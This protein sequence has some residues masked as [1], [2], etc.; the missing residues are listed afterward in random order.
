M[1]DYQAVKE[2]GKHDP[3]KKNK[4]SIKSDP[5]LTQTVKLEDYDIKSYCKCI[6]YVQKV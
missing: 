3:Y 5:E 1:K 6:L 2:V 4:L